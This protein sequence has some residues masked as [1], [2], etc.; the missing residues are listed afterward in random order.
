MPT[1]LRLVCNSWIGSIDEKGVDV[2]NLY[3]GET[4]RLEGIDTVVLSVRHL[5]LES[6]YFE[7]ESE[8]PVVHRVGDCVTPRQTDHAIFEG[9]LAGREMFDKQTCYV[10]PGA[11]ERYDPE[12]ASKI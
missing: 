11:I 9:F 12:R 3:S 8:L 7:L 4:E 1:C 6:L 10:E 5:P 2:F